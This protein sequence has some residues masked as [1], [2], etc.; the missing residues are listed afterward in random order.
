MDWVDTW[1]L[2]LV[3]VTSNVKFQAF[4]CIVIRFYMDSLLSE[5]IDPRFDRGL[6]IRPGI[7]EKKSLILQ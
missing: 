6:P 2:L 1:Y 5:I 3:G 4:Q 7:P